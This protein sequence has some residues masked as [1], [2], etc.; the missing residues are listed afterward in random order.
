MKRAGT[1]GKKTE[2]GR[3]ERFHFRCSPGFKDLLDQ[4]IE[5]KKEDCE[6]MWS[7]ADVL[8]MALIKYAKDLG[9]KNVPGK[10]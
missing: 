4:V 7:G 9:V 5:L 8:H 2:K 1:I 10:L 6:E 3:T